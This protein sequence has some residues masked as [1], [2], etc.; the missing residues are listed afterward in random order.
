M[1]ANV[2]DIPKYPFLVNRSSFKMFK[3]ISGDI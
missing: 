2:T 1:I 3:I